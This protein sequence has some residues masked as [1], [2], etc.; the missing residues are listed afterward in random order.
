[1]PLL[2]LGEKMTKPKTASPTKTSYH[3]I[4]AQKK[5]LIY[6]VSS[7]SANV[8][9]PD[10]SGCIIRKIPRKSNTPYYQLLTILIQFYNS[11]ESM[12][13]GFDLHEH[14]FRQA[15]F[16]SPSIDILIPSGDF[17]CKIVLI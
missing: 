12:Y 1:L 5:Q 10:L 16:P 11:G 13:E 14:R 8:A 4:S 2:F 17:D 7:F 6:I 3:K 9:T 15:L